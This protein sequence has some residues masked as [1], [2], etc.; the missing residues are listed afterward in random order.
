VSPHWW[1]WWGA[2][3]RASLLPHVQEFADRCLVSAGPSRRA[4]RR[5]ALRRQADAHSRPAH[6]RLYLS[7]A[8]M[9]PIGLG[10]VLSHSDDDGR[11]WSPPVLVG[12]A[13]HRGWG[14]SVGVAPRGAVYVAWWRPPDGCLAFD[15]ASPRRR[16]RASGVTLRSE[17]TLGAVACSWPMRP[18]RPLA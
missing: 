9:F 15:T 11:T 14:A 12:H 8:R 6:R 1:R 10:L 2:V 16:P 3:R 17:S 7:W 18:G 5:D 13:H 4:A